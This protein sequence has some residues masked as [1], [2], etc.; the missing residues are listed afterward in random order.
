MP[1]LKYD[2]IERD[3]DTDK[4]YGISIKNVKKIKEEDTI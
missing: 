4:E 3:T 2:F 1:G